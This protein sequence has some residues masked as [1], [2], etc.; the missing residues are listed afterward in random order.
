MTTFTMVI[1]ESSHGDLGILERTQGLGC[2]VSTPSSVCRDQQRA[3][4]HDRSRMAEGRLG[5][6]YNLRPCQRT[7]GAG[8]IMRGQGQ[9]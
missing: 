4:A 3:T 8:A 1:W 9:P 7:Y 5:G 2:L 6:P